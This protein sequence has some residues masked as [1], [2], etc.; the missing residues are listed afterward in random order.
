MKVKTLM[1]KSIKPVILLSVQLLINAYSYGQQQETM[2]DYLSE[3]FRNYVAS[4]PW[5]E[6]FIH[7]DRE[8]YISGED[9]WF[10][11]YLL[12]RKSLKPSSSSRIV[13]F[14]LLN[15]ENRPLIQ[16]RILLNNGFG[17]G[18]VQIPDTL[19]SGIYTIRAYTNWMKNFLPNNCF[20]KEI[21]IYNAINNSR[22]KGKSTTREQDKDGAGI[23]VQ[24]VNAGSLISLKTEKNLSGDLEITVSA[25]ENYIA[26][27]G[28]IFYIIIQA[29]GNIK[30]E[31]TQKLNGNITKVIV[32]VTKL[33]GG[34]NQI[35]VFDSKGYPVYEKYVYLHEEKGMGIRINSPDSCKTREKIRI[36]LEAPVALNENHSSGNFSLSVVPMPGKSRITSDLNEYMIFGSEF[37]LNELSRSFPGRLSELPPAGIDSLL[38]NIRS[39]W[40][41]WKQI[42]S[43]T[44][45]HFRYRAEKDDHFLP[46]RIISDVNPSHYQPESVLLCTPGREAEFQYTKTDKEGN[47][48][49]N[50]PIDEVYKDLVIM[51][52]IIGEKKKVILE[53]SYSGSYFKP[54]K[55]VDSSLEFLPQNI[56]EMGVNYQVRKIYGD[57]A[58]GKPLYRKFS[59]LKPVRF[60]GKPDIELKMEDYVILPR[61]EEVFF[62]LIP[63]VSLRKKNSVYTIFIA[64]RINENR[65]ELTPYLFLDGV[66]IRDASIIAELDP[67][68]VGRIDVIKE[69]YVVGTYFF[70]GIV[71]VITKASDFS[72]IPLPDYMVR[73]PYRAVDPVEEFVSPDYSSIENK[74]KPNPDFRNTLYWN[75]TLNP[76]K[77]GKITAE[78]WTS[79]FASDYE[80]II[81]GVTSEGRL[82]SVKKSLRVE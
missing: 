19:S 15:Y 30:F 55:R 27:K 58:S 37:G 38:Q 42:I 75:P 18:H 40:I 36:E 72:A 49:F 54:E 20:I 5:E 2:I 59:Q 71:N 69:K 82:I 66:K 35:T 78:F 51:P 46:G 80:I 32:P 62:E 17:P 61:M 11:A 64:D 53:S 65:Y 70:P 73:V 60:Y 22:F 33:T 52:D 13:Y 6:V 67:L 16:K 23:A 43:G 39:N 76:D 47:F 4:V 68:T 7:S 26:G 50:I 25:D 41:D 44:K 48:A 14:E 31:N 21:N 10:N 79:D 56:E 8:E 3:K 77:E 34:I 9:L 29:H 28:D 1:G 57:T 63:R 24:S 45:P 74:D 12:D 81:Q